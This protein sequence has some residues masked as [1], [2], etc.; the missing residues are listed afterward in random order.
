MFLQIHQ[1]S[2]VPREC[3]VDLTAWSISLREMYNVV[4]R[5]VP[6]LCVRTDV[7]IGELILWDGLSNAKKYGD[8]QKEPWLE[9]HVVSEENQ[10]GQTLVLAVCNVARA[11][12]PPITTAEA[13]HL[14]TGGTKGSLASSD[15]G[16]GCSAVCTSDGVG[17][18]NALKVATLAKGTL[19]LRQEVVG[20]ERITRLEVRLPLKEPATRPV[21]FVCISLMP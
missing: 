21:G 18:A 4:V 3:K 17:L 8:P 16:D 7:E 20:L 13:E 5:D 14:M 1:G 10:G 19:K 15:A 2:Y 9:M 11:N 12:E 6:Q